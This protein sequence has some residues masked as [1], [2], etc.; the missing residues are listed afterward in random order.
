M[1]KE[2]KSERERGEEEKNEGEK[3]K[4]R[5][6]KEER[7]VG[8]EREALKKRTCRVPKGKRRETK[9]GEI[10]GL[11]LDVS[12]LSPPLYLF[13]S[14]SLVIQ[15]ISVTFS[16]TNTVGVS[17]QVNQKRHPA[18]RSSFQINTTTYHKCF[19]RYPVKYALTCKH[20]QNRKS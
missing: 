11:I 19:C 13:L 12:I 6:R 2:K 7:K 5:R 17:V 9:D 15:F 1:W 20:F 10:E 18:P 14:P 4:R 16:L 3:I 8:R